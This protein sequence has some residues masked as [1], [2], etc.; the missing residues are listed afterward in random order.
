MDVRLIA[1]SNTDLEAAVADGRLREDLFYRLNVVRIHLPP[2]RERREDIPLLVT[3]FLQKF[4]AQLGREVP[5]LAPDALAMLEQYHWPGNIRE[6]E[7]VIERAVVLGPRDRLTVDSLPESLSLPRAPSGLDL[8]L[9][10]EG[11]NLEA[12]LDR[13]EKKLLQLAL[14]RTNG[15]Q[16]HAAELLG[17]TF[18]QFRYKL[19]KHALSRGKPADREE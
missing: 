10:P 15:V 11:L 9:P 7:N 18:R 16:T 17:M 13:L 14:D 12:T 5:A 8:D 19:Q 3:S 1:A 2:L 4:A 6:L